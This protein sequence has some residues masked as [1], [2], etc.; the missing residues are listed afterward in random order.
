MH[1]SVFLSKPMEKTI[2]FAGDGNIAIFRMAV[3]GA[4]I[5]EDVFMIIYPDGFSGIQKTI[6]RN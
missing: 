6:Y 4:Y 3:V 2:W 5:R 1:V